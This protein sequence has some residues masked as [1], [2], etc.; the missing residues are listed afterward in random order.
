MFITSHVLTKHNWTMS[1]AQPAA[2][3]VSMRADVKINP[4]PQ[5][6]ESYGWVGVWGHN[7]LFQTGWQSFQGRI[8]PFEC[9]ISKSGHIYSFN[10]FGYVLRNKSYLPLAIKYHSGE[11]SVWFK[12]DGRWRFGGRTRLPFQPGHEQ[13]QVDTEVY[14]GRP[15]PLI[16]NHQSLHLSTP[17]VLARQL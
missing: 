7:I 13:F 12:A 6:G 2:Y 4:Q 3:V 14:G 15:L 10:H 16:V 8:V 9:L 17:T 11:W 1:T 5:E